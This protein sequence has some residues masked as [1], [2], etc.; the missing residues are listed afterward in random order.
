MA[1]KK[2]FRKESKKLL[3]QERY[4][5]IRTV[6]ESDLDHDSYVD[7]LDKVKKIDEILETKKSK[8][9]AQVRAAVIKGI[10]SLI[11]I[12]GI[13]VYENRHVF[14]SKTAVNTATKQL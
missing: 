2:N 11:S 9:D 14:H 7:E 8:D 5:V 13:V 1:K 4:E 12:A 3:E 10:F 6:T